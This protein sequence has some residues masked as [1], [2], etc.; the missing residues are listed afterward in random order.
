MK[1]LIIP[2]CLLFAGTIVVAGINKK[3]T[4]NKTQKIQMTN[5]L[6]NAHS[7]A[8]IV[9]IQKS[10]KPLSYKNKPEPAVGDV[11][12]RTTYDLQTNSGMSRRVA[13][14]PND[15]FTYVGWAFDFSFT[16]GG[17]GRG[18]GFNYY[19][20]NTGM[21]GNEPTMRIEPNTRTGWPFQLHIQMDRE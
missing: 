13:T 18:T 4:S 12:G 17:T 19:D 3:K 20:N 7:T 11:V 1:Y 14:N 9:S 5:A 6:E 10:T 15:R 21:W 8:K 2:L 16:F